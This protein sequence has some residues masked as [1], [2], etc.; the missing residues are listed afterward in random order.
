MCTFAGHA[1][2]SVGRPRPLEEATPLP[3]AGI[4]A[5]GLGQYKP[6]QTSMAQGKIPVQPHMTQY[7]PVQPNTDQYNPV[8]PSTAWGKLPVWPSMAQYSP[9]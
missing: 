9:V 6:V 1:H 5:G 2:L 4:G 8:Q 3:S 7:N